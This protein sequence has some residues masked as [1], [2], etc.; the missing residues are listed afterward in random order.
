ML[1]AKREL[2]EEAGVKAGRLE[3]MFTL[4]PTPGYTSEKIYIY[5]A[6]DC[7]KVNAHLDEGEFLDIEYIPLKKAKEM[8]K[9]GEIKYGK[10]IIALQA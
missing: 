1:A 2:A 3:L 6:F 5:Q 7:E 10:T 8:L 4:Y 9:N